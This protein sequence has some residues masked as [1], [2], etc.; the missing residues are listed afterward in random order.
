[1]LVV[2]NALDECCE[3]DVR[4]VVEGLSQLVR[5]FK[6]ILTTRPYYLDHSLRNQGGHKLFHL[7][8]IESK[9]VDSD[10]RLYLRYK[11]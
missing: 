9:V 8:D 6:V 1:M 11:L 2:V 3:E 5:S 4:V 7:Q 10:I